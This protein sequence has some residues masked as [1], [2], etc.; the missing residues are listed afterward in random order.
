[1][2]FVK[3]STKACKDNNYYPIPPTAIIIVAMPNKKTAFFPSYFSFCDWLD[4]PGLFHDVRSQEA[5]QN[6]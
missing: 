3:I 5:I 2:T 6:N 4:L 1:L